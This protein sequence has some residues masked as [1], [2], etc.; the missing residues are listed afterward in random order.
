MSCYSPLH[1]FVVG[2]TKN[3]KMK[4]QVMSSDVKALD[5]DGQPVY[6]EVG[7]DTDYR[8][9][10]YEL[11][12]GH[13]LGCRVDH[14]K[15]WSNRLIMESQY[16]DSTYFVTLTYDDEH[17][18]VVEQLDE[19]TG[20]YTIN[21]SLN[22]RDVQLF[23]KSLRKRFP[24]DR[25]RYYVAGEYGPSTKR[26]H[27]HAIIFG[28]HLVDLQPFGRSETGNQYF[29]SQT[30]SDIWS[31]GF[32]SVEPANE[33]TI[34]YVCAYVTTK[35]GARCN[36]EY[37]E[38]GLVPPFAMMSLKP[39]LGC[40]Y[41]LDHWTEILDADVV[42]FG[43]ENGSHVFRPPRYWYKKVDEYGLMYPEDIEKYK[44]HNKKKACD[45]KEGALSRTDVSWKELL[46]NRSDLHARKYRLRDG[47]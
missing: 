16:H 41:L 47:V 25:I 13:C 21:S 35:I 33:Y 3:G 9:P 20:E 22:K 30:L 37:E 1:G 36:Q 39:G 44:V 28:L 15:E 6:H 27:Y 43:D 18:P 17:I 5:K 46:Q 19:E 24:D 32:V 4:L 14:A 29:I 7:D 2:Q 31:R 40:Q 23:I 38:R 12:C 45:I 11:P 10:A 42:V 8:L 26:A 34:R